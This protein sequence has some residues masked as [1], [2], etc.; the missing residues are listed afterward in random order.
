MTDLR[1][2]G[3]DSPI[4]PPMQVNDAK[5]GG[6]TRRRAVSRTPAQG[7]LALFRPKNRD[8]STVW[9]LLLTL[10]LFLRHVLAWRPSQQTSAR[11]SADGIRA[12]AD[13]ALSFAGGGFVPGSY[14]RWRSAAPT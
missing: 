10:G 11:K 14:H 8:L 3:T 2:R 6:Q 4:I 9:G 12:C 1:T 13:L 5:C 7:I